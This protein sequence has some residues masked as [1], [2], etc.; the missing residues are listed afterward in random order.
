MKNTKA[1]TSAGT[2][3]DLNYST[4]WGK[5]WTLSINQLFFYTALNNSLVFRENPTNNFFFENADGLVTST[6]LETN[7]KLT[8]KDFKLFVN[9]ALIDTRLRF[10]NL[11][12][13]KP[14]TPKHNIGA[15]LMYEEHG[16]W[17]I[18]LESYYT[19]SQFL[20]D[21]SKTNDYWIAGLMMMR[22]W[23]NIA[24]YLNFENFTDTRQ[25]KLEAFDITEHIRPS[26]PQIWAP[27][28]GFIVNGGVIVELM[29]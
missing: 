4:Y 16:K 6:G 14:L 22:K 25:H 26:F 15:V 3:F 18:G 21:Q 27:T 8:Y 24:F 2:N 29:N 10:D 11:N 7:V 12:R 17:R 19:G 9:Y 13:Q 5:D 23:K 20:A 1:E 28:D